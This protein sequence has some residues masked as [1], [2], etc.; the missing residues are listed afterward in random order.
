MLSL[1]LRNE[2]LNDHDEW[3]K[4][5]ALQACLRDWQPRHA[6][7]QPLAGKG[8]PNLQAM[9]AADSN[10]RKVPQLADVGT[11]NSRATL[12]TGGTVDS[13]TAWMAD[14]TVI[15]VTMAC[16]AASRTPPSS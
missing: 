4:N 1:A 15:T 3:C 2:N 7:C 12:T 9:S 11:Q 10:A 6:D 5:K 16:R 8:T 14:P 13:R